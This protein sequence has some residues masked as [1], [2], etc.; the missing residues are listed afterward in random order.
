MSYY[1]GKLYSGAPLINIEFVT[2]LGFKV[3]NVETTVKDLTTVGADAA[4]GWSFL[5]HFKFGFDSKDGIFEIEM[6]LLN[7]IKAA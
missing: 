3:E 6:F 5:R 4:V 7:I 2:V 1:D